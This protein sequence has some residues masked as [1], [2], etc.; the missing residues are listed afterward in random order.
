MPIKGTDGEGNNIYRLDFADL[1]AV[2]FRGVTYDPN[3]AGPSGWT[4]AGVE[5]DFGVRF[6]VDTYPAWNSCY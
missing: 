2:N 5:A 3:A 6:G 4:E 1:L